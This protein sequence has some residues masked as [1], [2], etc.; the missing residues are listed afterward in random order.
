MVFVR[1]F[2]EKQRTNLAQFP[3]GYKQVI[4]LTMDQQFVA[5]IKNTILVQLYIFIWLQNFC[6]VTDLRRAPTSA[7]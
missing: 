6:I 4:L 7:I 5:I 3:R 1:F 2:G